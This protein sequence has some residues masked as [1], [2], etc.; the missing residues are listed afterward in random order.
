MKQNLNFGSKCKSVGMYKVKNITTIFVNY[1]EHV[2]LNIV[3]NYFDQFLSKN[4]TT[5]KYCDH[6]FRQTEQEKN[7]EKKTR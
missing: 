1:V 3:I 6:T 7:K 5:V 4:K 2:F